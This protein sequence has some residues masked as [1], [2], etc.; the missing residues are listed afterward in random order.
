[1]KTDELESKIK[2]LDEMAKHTKDDM[3]ALMVLSDFNTVIQN[4]RHI[5]WAAQL[6][7]STRKIPGLLEMWLQYLLLY[8]QHVNLQRRLYGLELDILHKDTL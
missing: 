6:N 2:E 8:R 3:T 1:M 7:K 4:L 5:V